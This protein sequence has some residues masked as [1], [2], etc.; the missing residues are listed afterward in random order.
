V[1]DHG[2]T[3]VREVI[4]STSNGADV[5]SALPGLV[6]QLLD[7]EAWREFTV[8]GL[9]G[10][11]QHETFMSFVKTQPPRGL[12]GKAA[13]LLALCGADG[14]L[15]A[16]VDCLL[17]GEVQRAATPGRPKKDST[18]IVSS[19]RGYT[20]TTVVARLKRDDPDLAQ[21]VVNGEMSAYAA[22]RAK[23][24]KPPR[25]QVTTPERTAAHLC[26]HMT[27]DQLDELVNILIGVIDG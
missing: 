24:W 8:Q 10:P 14:E 18:T 23:G 22:A 15:R 20:A 19:D 5:M 11:V 2:S 27:R 6:R 1:T 12:G 21:R 3:I 26:R 4:T 17:K 16:R 9:R 25:I 13:A 7:E